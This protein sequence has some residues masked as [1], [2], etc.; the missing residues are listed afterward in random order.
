M[1]NLRAERTRKINTTLELVRKKVTIKWVTNRDY[2]KISSSPRSYRGICALALWFRSATSYEG[3]E[4]ARD[5]FE[6][7]IFASDEASREFSLDTSQLAQFHALRP[8]PSRLNK[9]FSKEIAPAMQKV[10]FLK[11]A[12]V[13]AQIQRQLLSQNIYK[14]NRYCLKTLLKCIRNRMVTH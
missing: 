7:D 9:A 10:V 14:K 5:I 1:A 2:L 13:K 11:A 3:D 12:K 4:S 8:Q 6:R